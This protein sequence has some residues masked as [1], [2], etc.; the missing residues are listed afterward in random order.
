MHPTL[1]IQLTTLSIGSV[2]CPART[3]GVCRAVNE[4]FCNYFGYWFSH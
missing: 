2:A 4:G 1:A 3:A